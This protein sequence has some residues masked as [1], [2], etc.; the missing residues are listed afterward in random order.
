MYMGNQRYWETNYEIMDSFKKYQFLVVQ[1]HLAS[2]KQTDMLRYY[3]V[4]Q[5]KLRYIKREV[6]CSLETYWEQ[7]V[8]YLRADEED[9]ED[10]D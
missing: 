2:R 7:E 5:Q 9:P 1:Y 8:A 6:S 4:P 3:K 10:M